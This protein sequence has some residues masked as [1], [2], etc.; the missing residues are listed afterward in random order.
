MTQKERQE[1][2]KQEILEAALKEFGA[3]GYSQVN[4]EHICKNHGISKGMMYHYYSNKD[5]LFLLCVRHVFEALTDHI[6]QD[7]NRMADTVTQ[8]ESQKEN[9]ALR[10]IQSFFMLRE[11]FFLLHPEYKRIFEN[12]MLWPPEHLLE[13]IQALRKPLRRLNQVFLEHIV[14]SMPLR[15]GLDQKKVIRYLESTEAIF[16]SIQSSYQEE[17]EASDLHTMLE[18]AAELLDMVLFGVLQ[19]GLT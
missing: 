11:H 5:E 15:P 6:E 14:S 2:S 16:R 3:N 12:A 17:H 9:S 1:R 10:H 7:M 4:M 19:Q 13:E 8:Q 18:T